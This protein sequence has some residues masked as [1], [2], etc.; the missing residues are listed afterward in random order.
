MGVGHAHCGNPKSQ[1]NKILVPYD[2]SESLA[3]D[4]WCPRCRSFNFIDDFYTHSGKPNGRVSMCKPCDQ[5][6]RNA[7]RRLARRR[8]RIDG[9]SE[10]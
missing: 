1:A 9:M 10:V 6:Y 8:K 4:I 3:P 2:P 7:K 5:A